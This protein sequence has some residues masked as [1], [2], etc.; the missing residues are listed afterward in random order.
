VP[1]VA[2]QRPLRGQGGFVNIAFPLSRIFNAD[3]AGRNA[4]WVFSAHYGF[5]E[6]LARDV[7]RLNAANRQKS[8]MGAGTL[9]YK[10]NN[11]V[12]FVA[13]ETLYRTRALPNAAGVF[14]SFDGRPTREWKDFRSEIGPIFSF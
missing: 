11:F 10:L 2:P 3:P 7:R 12:T 13:E 6:A 1:V 9:Q 4:G 14:P 5:D 8:D